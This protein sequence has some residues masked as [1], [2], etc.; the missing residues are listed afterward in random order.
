MLQELVD[1]YGYIAVAVGSLLEGE[2]VLLL[3]GAAIDRGYLDFM[4]VVLLAFVGGT[5]GDQIL[6]LLGRRY[7]TALLAASPKWAERAKPVHRLIERHGDGLIVAVRF[8]YGLRLIGPFVIGTSSVALHR[9]ALFNML[10]AAI[11][12]PL[13][14]GVGYF[15]GQAIGWL[16]DDL[17]HYE[18][19]AV[20]V[21]IAVVVA[22]VVLRRR[23]AAGVARRADA[24][25]AVRRT[26]PTAAAPRGRR[27]TPR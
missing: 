8:L 3:A 11:W 6:F 23:R 19:V 2:T 15:F 16:I 18:A 12:A 20:V 24:A 27:P 5:L 4:P 13:V 14:V 21:A 25:A 22:V 1:Q 26:E 9:F 7:G 17:G 10:G